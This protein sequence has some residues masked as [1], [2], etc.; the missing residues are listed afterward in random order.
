MCIR[1]RRNHG[2]SLDNHAALEVLAGHLDVQFRPGNEES[3]EA[4]IILEGDDVTEQVRSEE[5]GALAS[6][7]AA[8]GVV[9][10]ALLVRQRA[11]KIR[12]GLVADGRDMGTVV[13][14]EAQLKVFLTASADE[15]ASRRYEQLKN[16]GGAVSPVSYTHLRAHETVL[17]L[18]CRLLL[19]KKKQQT[20][21]FLK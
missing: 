3:A 8:I 15:R 16:T 13:F 12:P 21:V 11:F 10:S 5:V 2:V 14:P 4:R 19:E 6:H 7:V 20:K 1:D 18:V 17:D 9:R